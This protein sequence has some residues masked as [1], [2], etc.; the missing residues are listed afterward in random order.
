MA[1]YNSL[2]T[3]SAPLDYTQNEM[4]IKEKLL[5]IT[6]SYSFYFLWMNAI[7]IEKSPERWMKVH[8]LTYFSLPPPLSSENIREKNRGSYMSKCVSA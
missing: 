3:N 4:E 5:V 7:P 6:D 8:P 2:L 1:S